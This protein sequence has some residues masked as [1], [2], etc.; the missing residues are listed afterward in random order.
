LNAIPDI[1][2]PCERR[3]GK[4]D[5]NSYPFDYSQASQKA[6]LGRPQLLHRISHSSNGQCVSKRLTPDV[7]VPNADQFQTLT[8]LNLPC[9]EIGARG[10]EHLAR[11]LRVNQ[12]SRLLFM[13][14]MCLT[15]KT[16]IGT[17]NTG[18]FV[19]ADRRCRPGASGGCV[20]GEHG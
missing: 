18:A 2:K 17:K 6:C 15:V 20:A 16:V 11:A 19:Q 14:C 1:D 13:F 10:A 12:V 5:R 8:T 9:N 3:L 4:F 7:Q